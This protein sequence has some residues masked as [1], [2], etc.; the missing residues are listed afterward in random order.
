M[1]RPQESI[2]HHLPC[3]TLTIRILPDSIAARAIAGTMAAIAKGN[4]DGKTHIAPLKK[5]KKVK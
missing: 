3:G 5:S 1:K 4:W 2:D